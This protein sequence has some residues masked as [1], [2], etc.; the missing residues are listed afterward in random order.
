MTRPVHSAAVYF[1]LLSGAA[2]LTVLLETPLCAL[3]LGD[4]SERWYVV[5][6]AA[7]VNLLTNVLI[8]WV[9]I[10]LLSRT[11]LARVQGGLFC[12]LLPELLLAYAAEA[13]LYARSIPDLPRGRAALASLAANTLSLAAGYAVSA[14]LGI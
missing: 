6:L 9:C 4:R 14:L 12:V 5:R 7:V 8:N 1:L 3:L 2:V 10:P 11:A 13:W